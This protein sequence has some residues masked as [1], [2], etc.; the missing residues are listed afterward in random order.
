MPKRPTILKDDEFLSFVSRRQ[1]VNW[2]TFARLKLYEDSL[3]DGADGTA[4]DEKF[5]KMVEAEDD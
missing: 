4:N 2:K 1:R 5:A 3:K